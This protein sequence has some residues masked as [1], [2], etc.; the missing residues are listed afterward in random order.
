MQEDRICIY[1]KAGKLFKTDRLRQ[2]STENILEGTKT[3]SKKGGSVFET[4]SQ[5]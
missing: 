5:L 1:P 2:N 4:L 3:T